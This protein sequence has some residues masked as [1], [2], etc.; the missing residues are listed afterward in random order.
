MKRMAF[1]VVA[2]SITATAQAGGMWSLIN[3]QFASNAWYC[4]YQ[5][6]GT[7]IQRTIQSNSGCKP[8]I[9]E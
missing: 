7:T 8:F 5:L 9:F 4:T 3:Q 6:Q 1:I 2:L